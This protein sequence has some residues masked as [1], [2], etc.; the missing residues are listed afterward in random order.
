MTYEKAEGIARLY[1]NDRRNE[2]RLLGK[3]VLTVARETEPE[4]METTIAA[5]LNRW[6][7]AAGDMRLD[8][9]LEGTP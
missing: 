8:L 2:F 4:D 6:Q 5:V 9:E 3:F 7:E 1:M